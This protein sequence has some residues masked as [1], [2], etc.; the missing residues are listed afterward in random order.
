MRFSLVNGA[1]EIVFRY[2]LNCC[3]APVGVDTYGGGRASLIGEGEEQVFTWRDRTGDAWVF[4]ATGG[5]LLSYSTQEGV[6][7]EDVSADLVVVRDSVDGTLR[8]IWSYWDGLF[9]IENI[10]ACGYTMSLYTPAAVSGRGDD[11]L[12]RLVEGAVAFKSFVISYEEEARALT[13]VQK[14]VDAPDDRVVWTQSA[15]G[16]WSMTR[17]CGQEAITIAR[18]R[19]QLEPAALQDTLDVWQLV[20]EI[21]KAG[22]V[23]S[24]EC[25]VYQSTPVGNLLLTRVEGYGSGSELTTTYTYDGAG[26][27]FTQT[28]PNGSVTEYVYD[29]WGRL[30]RTYEEW[31]AVDSGY[32]KIS[33]VVYADSGADNFSS[34]PATISEEYNTPEGV[35][36]SLR[37]DVYTYHTSG[38]IKRVEVRSTAAGRSLEGMTAGE[39]LTVT[40]TYGGE[41][42]NIFARGHLRMRQ[43]VNGVQTW[44][45]YAAAPDEEGALYTQ[46][47]ETR[48]NGSAVPGQSTRTVNYI[49][50]EGNT[51]RSEKYVLLADKRWV[52]ISAVASTYDEQNRL[53][54]TEQA[55]GRRMTQALNCE[56]ELRWRVDEDGVRTDY[57]YDSARQLIETTRSEVRYNEEVITPEI[58]T[59]YTRDA[60]GRVVRTT[61][62]SGAMVTTESTAYDLAGR[63]ISQTDT[64]GRVTTT[65]Y[66]DDTLTTTVTLPSGAT[67]ITTRNLDGTRA[68]EYGTG[69]REQLYVYAYD[70]GLSTATTLADGTLLSRSLMDGFGQVITQSTPSTLAGSSISKLSTYNALG[71]IVKQTLGNLA[72]MTYAYDRMGNIS[73]QTVLLDATAP[74]DTTANRITE[75]A[76]GYEQRDDGV[77]QVT[78]TTSYNAAGS[79]SSARNKS[80]SRS[81]R[82]PLKRRGFPSTLAEMFLPNGQS[83]PPRMSAPTTAISPLP[84]SSPP[85]FRWMVSPSPPRTIRECAPPSREP[86]EDQAGCTLPRTD[87]TTLRPRARILQGEQ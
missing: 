14:A 27:V 80:L 28:S 2:D 22:V 49:S 24:R 74:A 6:I 76:Y 25:E 62:Y 58:I 86:V 71:Q 65:A 66:S 15:E 55:N 7:I 57:V 4:S 51:L 38:G 13:L 63:V 31:G 8:Q 72:P 26:N 9:N 33:Q 34:Q 59:E 85:R 1:R 68:R 48:V 37:Q 40:E 19:T 78:S 64:L 11:G 44:Y 17:G 82:L 12:Y 46:S 10:S 83:T 47:V 56:G 79:P 21:S 52:K 36:Q 23:A 54:A 60:A 53:T 42:E 32:T 75:Y 70:D 3:I 84:I 43:A 35:R 67:L 87:A 30:L 81:F 73:V 5:E 61:T 16:A 39:R 41:V 77:Y 20:T 69:Q 18:T 29:T 50:C 45:E